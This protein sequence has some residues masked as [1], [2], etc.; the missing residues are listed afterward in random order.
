MREIKFRAKLINGDYVY[1]SYLFNPDG[2]SIVTEKGLMYNVDDET[3]GQFTGC[4]DA[5]GKEIYEGDKLVDY[6]GEIVTVQWEGA[7]FWV[8]GGSLDEPLEEVCEGCTVITQG[9]H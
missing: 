7:G 8:T 6:V 4:H 1:G 9:R 3:V 5:D 2:S